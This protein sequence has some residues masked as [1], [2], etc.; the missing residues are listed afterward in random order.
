MKSF[1]VIHACA[2]CGDD[3]S[4]G[5]VGD[6]PCCF[7]CY[8][9]GEARNPLV[10]ENQENQNKQQ[11][12]ENTIMSKPVLISKILDPDEFADKAIIMCIEGT[13]T[14]LYDATTGDDYEYQN[15]EFK[16][17]TGKTIKITFS[18]CT[19]PSTA[20]GKKVT[21]SAVKSDKHGW[22]GLKVEDKTY[23]SKGKEV[24]ERIIKVTATAQIEYGGA[25]SNE[26]SGSSGSGKPQSVGT[27]SGTQSQPKSDIHP[28]KAI[29]DMLLLHVAITTLVNETYGEKISDAAKQGAVA[30]LFIE[31]AKQGLVWDFE[32]RNAKELPKQYPPAPKDP[33]DWKNCVIPKG[34][35]EGK[36]LEELPED[37]LLELF[38]V[39]DD[40]GSNTPFAE[41][42]YQAAKDRDVLPKDDP[43]QPES[44]DEPEEDS[45]PF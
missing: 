9:S 28:K 15:G 1:P 22:Q 7:E 36:T 40:K 16:D 20:K 17:S 43:K 23:T 21:I 18:K 27:G 26:G 10:N 25:S 12:P 34:E 31:S 33:K 4:G 6:N 32:K 45:I 19:Q 11:Q 44:S 8:T 3:S 5:Y 14:K 30:T 29:G 38:N 39:L 24:S 37:R 2:W 41:C 13:L 42:V 35:F